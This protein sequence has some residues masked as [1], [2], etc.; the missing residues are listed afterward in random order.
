MQIRD[1]SVLPVCAMRYALGRHSYI[2]SSVITE[3]TY[4]LTKLPDN[5]LHV[6]E[7]DIGEHLEN[8]SKHDD[9]WGGID[10]RAWKQFG[11]AIHREVKRRNGLHR[12]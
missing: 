9:S 8:W 11:E 12:D 4:M 2:V 3:L 6:M 10:E 5:D 1:D 7:R